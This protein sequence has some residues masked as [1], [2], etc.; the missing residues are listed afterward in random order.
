[1]TYGGPERRENEWL[2]RDTVCENEVNEGVG[3]GKRIEVAAL[4][5]L[6]M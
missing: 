1:M 2:C 5:R 4:V 6:G 3:R